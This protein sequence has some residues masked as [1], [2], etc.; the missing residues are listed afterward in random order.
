MLFLRNLKYFFTLARGF[1]Q[2]KRIPMKRLIVSYLSKTSRTGWL[3][4]IVV[5]QLLFVYAFHGLFSFSVDKISALS[6]GM[7]IPDAQM[8]YTS[9]QLQNMFRLYGPE[10]RE[11]YLRLQWIDMVYPLIYSTLLASL[12]YLV[13]KKTRLE[14]MVFVPFVAALF[15][16][17]ENILLRIS[18]LSFPNMQDGVVSIAGTVT[19]IKWLLVFFAFFLLLFGF[20][21]RVAHHRFKKKQAGR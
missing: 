13:Y 18:I 6:N 7:G 5:L 17:A 4:L 10:G 14:N 16:Y 2:P 12:L 1:R 19:F 3:L 11:M 9:P 8:F 21:W 20:I 15:D